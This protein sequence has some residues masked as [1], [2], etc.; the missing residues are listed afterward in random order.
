[1]DIESIFIASYERIIGKGVGITDR[2]RLFFCRFYENFLASS[3][4]VRAKFSATDMER[5][6]QV[7]QKGLYQLITFYLTKTDS[8]FLREVARAHDEDHFSIAPDLYDLWLEALLSTVEE[9]DPEY[10]RD[11]A[12]A[13]R[14][15]MAPGILYMKHHHASG[16]RASDGE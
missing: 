1:M 10:N 14:I 6:Q 16:E 12:L 9:M 5:Q 4:R 3:D 8:Q 15:V 7:L 13:W 11:L 2:G